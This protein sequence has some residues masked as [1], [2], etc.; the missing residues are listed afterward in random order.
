MARILDLGG[1]PT[2]ALERLIWLDGVLDQVH[3]ELDPE[4]ARAYFDARLQGRLDE[5]L[6]LE[7]HSRKRVMA[8]TRHHNEATGRL[9][10]WNDGRG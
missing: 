6:A 4:W 2:D 10:R 9:I 7:L 1:L 5:A 8:W 3:T